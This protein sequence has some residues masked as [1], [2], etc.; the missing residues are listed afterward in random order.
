MESAFGAGSTSPD[1]LAAQHGRSEV[2]VKDSGIAW[3]VTQ[4]TFVQDDLINH[5]L[6]SIRRQGAF[7]GASGDA[8]IADVSAADVG[9]VAAMILA[10]P[11]SRDGNSADRQ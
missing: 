10:N 6:D 1:A 7:Y 5:A 8:R 3:T 11:Q 2:R 9:A 4:P